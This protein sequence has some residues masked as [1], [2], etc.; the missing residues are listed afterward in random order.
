MIDPKVVTE[1]K[2]S[3]PAPGNLT[4]K[5]PKSPDPSKIPPE[6]AGEALFG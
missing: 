6:S 5:P 1:T 3:R 2:A 4:G